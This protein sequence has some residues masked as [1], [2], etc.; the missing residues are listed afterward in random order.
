M[1]YLNFHKDKFR[2]LLFI[3]FFNHYLSFAYSVRGTDS[4][5]GSET[6]EHKTYRLQSEIADLQER[7]ALSKKSC[8]EFLLKNINTD[9]HENLRTWYFK[10]A[11][12][13][14][15]FC[16]GPVKNLSEVPS[17]NE[18]SKRLADHS[19]TKLGDDNQSLSESCISRIKDS[20]RKNFFVAEYYS[21]MARLKVA[22]LSTL[23]SLQS[24]DS[25]LGERSLSDKSC[26][27]IGH[28]LSRKGCEKL[29]SCKPQGGLVDQA[30]ELENI[31][32]QY[33]S[34]KKEVNDLRSRAATS[35]MVAG[36]GFIPSPSLISENAERDRKVKENVDEIQL[37]EAMYPALK[38]KAFQKTLDSSKNNFEESLKKQL[39]ET[40]DKISFEFQELQKATRC[41]SGDSRECDRFDDI[42]KKT[43]PL[44]VEAFKSGNGLTQE[45]AEVQVHLNATDCF[46]KVRKAK[47]NQEEAVNSFL[48]NSGLTVLTMGLS[49]Y[50]TYGRLA[51]MGAQEAKLASTAIKAS[52]EIARKT[53]MASN[54]A[55]GFDLF[56]LGKGGVDAYQKCS[57]DL[58]KLTHHGLNKRHSNSEVSCA[59]NPSQSSQ[60]QLIANY[61]ACVVHSIFA[62]ASSI[63]LPKN[64]KKTLEGSFKGLTKAGKKGIGVTGNLN[65]EEGE[66]KESSN[67]VPAS[68]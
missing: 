29:Q 11:G 17:S 56:S 38:G 57:K 9:A 16:S 1:F 49:S 45:D 20:S 23:E 64:I 62:G 19:L 52:T 22:S 28:S 34:L 26:S 24:I 5:D 66:G 60:A 53:K 43:P 54:T 25:V 7:E 39:K 51:Y 3:S 4:F 15:D 58:N 14:D 65:D 21:N 47:K 41:M 37:I 6:H 44:N 2:F 42:L 40:R 18:L 63:I 35:A 12:S 32:P 36:P 59:E 68:E 27:S 10:K 13:I 46:Q 30:K 67:R 48:V 50:S 8:P 55:L 31:Y 33:M 61:R